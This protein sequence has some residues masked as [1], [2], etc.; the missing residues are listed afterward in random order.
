MS[1]TFRAIVLVFL[2]LLEDVAWHGDIEGAVMIIPF[3]AYA[4]IQIFIPIFGEIIFF[5]D[6]PDEVVYVLLA[7]VLHSKIVNN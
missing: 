4:T 7:C 5:F 1:G 6:H 2:Q 3:E